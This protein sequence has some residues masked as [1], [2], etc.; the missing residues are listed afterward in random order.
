LRVGGE[1]SGVVD[2]SRGIGEIS[3]CDYEDAGGTVA[4][5][6]VHGHAGDIAGEVGAAVFEPVED[7]EDVMPFA[8][9]EGNVA[10][11]RVIEVCH[12]EN[13]QFGV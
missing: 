11:I 5:E 9:W 13:D 6:V 10:I 1:L 8:V 4:D 12:V 7:S 3:R 2:S